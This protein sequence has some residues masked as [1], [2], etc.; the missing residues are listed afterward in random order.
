MFFS[1]QSVGTLTTDRISIDRAAATTASKVDI[2]IGAGKLTLR[3]GSEKFIDGTFE[4]NVT[5]LTKTESLSNTTQEIDLEMRG[6]W[7]G[8]RS[9]RNELE[10]ELSKD[11]PTDLFIDSGAMDMQ[12]DM[13]EVM[14]QRLSID[15][16][17]SNLDL[18]LG[19]LVALSEIQVKAGASSVNISVP[20]TVGVKLNIDAGL[21]S[22]T[23]ED[24]TRV[25]ENVYESDDYDKAEKK[26]EIDLDLGV[27]SLTVTWR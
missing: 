9:T 14:L 18:D 20:R 16:G 21:T 10:L 8:F 24:F 19:D 1:N 25:D 4:S 23:F 17:A 26:I 11:L 6:Q 22:K 2:S 13:T 5:G 7:R 3:G 15:T 12:L 27:S